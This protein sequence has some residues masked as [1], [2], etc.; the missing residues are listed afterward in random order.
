M[1]KS[2]VKLGRLMGA[3]GFIHRDRLFRQPCRIRGEAS[4]SVN[5]SALDASSMPIC[6]A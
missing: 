5:A 6:G 3:L 2:A 1:T 4:W